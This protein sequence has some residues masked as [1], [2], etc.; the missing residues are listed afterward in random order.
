[1]GVTKEITVSK[2]LSAES[3]T[4]RK[5]EV[6]EAFK[7]VEWP[8]DDKAHT[9]LRLKV[10]ATSDKQIGWVNKSNIKAW[11]PDYKVQVPTALQDTRGATEVTKTIRELHKGEIVEYLEGPFA[12]GDVIRLK[13]KTK[14]DS[15]VGWVTIRD[16]KGQRH[17]D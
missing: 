8:K 16:E 15:V 3:D 1:M 13:V 9:E 2:K 10:R 6:G 5:L 14:K 7:I 11:Q 17:L 12:D 4:I